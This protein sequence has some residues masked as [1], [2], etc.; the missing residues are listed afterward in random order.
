MTGTPSKPPD[1]PQHGSQGC[2]GGFKHHLGFCYKKPRKNCLT[3]W[4]HRDQES[5]AKALQRKLEN[6]IETTGKTC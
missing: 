2:W 6:E 1:P 5:S 4:W 3:C